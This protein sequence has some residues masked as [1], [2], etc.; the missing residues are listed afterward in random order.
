MTG[1]YLTKLRQ[2]PKHVRDN[3]AF[4]IA[5]GF[6]AIIALFLVFAVHGPKVIEGVATE[7]DSPH[8]F[9]TLTGQIKDQ[10]AATRSSFEAQKPQ[11]PEVSAPS[12]PAANGNGEP[13]PAVLTSTAS[14]TAT[15]TMPRTVL[16][17][18]TSSSTGAVR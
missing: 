12:T 1:D 7:D 8:F 10:V 9:Q 5:S 17:A 13:A 2:K 14:G 4:G 18:T 11:K 6:T 15:T 16:I 3:I